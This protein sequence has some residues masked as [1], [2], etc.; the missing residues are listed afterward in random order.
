MGVLVVVVWFCDST[1]SIARLQSRIEGFTLIMAHKLF[2]LHMNTLPYLSVKVFN[3]YT[4]S[5][6]TK[7]E[8]LYKDTSL[9]RTPFPTTSTLAC[10]TRTI[11]FCPIRVHS[12]KQ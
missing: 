2:K 4:N 11:F 1:N 5:T 3:N 10:S 9:N 7:V 12:R 6:A 8:P